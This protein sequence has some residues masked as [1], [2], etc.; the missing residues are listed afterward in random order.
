MKIN[1]KNQLD[2]KQEQQRLKEEQREKDK[3]KA[4][5][6][7][8]GMLPKNFAVIFFVYGDFFSFSAYF[9]KLYFTTSFIFIFSFSSEETDIG[10]KFI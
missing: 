4:D 6:D 1:S 2:E 5:Q 9:N 8:E 10:T 7:A 3:I